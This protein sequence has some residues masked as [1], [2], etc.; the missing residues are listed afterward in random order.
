MKIMKAEFHII[1]AGLLPRDLQ[2]LTK[3]ASKES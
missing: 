1:Q 2:N 3:K